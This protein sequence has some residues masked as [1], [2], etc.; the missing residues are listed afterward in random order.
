MAPSSTRMRLAIISRRRFSTGLTGRLR[1]MGCTTAD[2]GTTLLAKRQFYQ[3]VINQPRD[4]V[5]FA[6]TP[7]RCAARRGVLQRPSACNHRVAF[8]TG[9]CDDQATRRLPIMQ[10][11]IEKTIELKAPVAR[12]WRALTD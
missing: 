11:R 8:P 1:G 10:D 7:D 6:A 9:W 5:A 2:M 12:V 4:K 3:G